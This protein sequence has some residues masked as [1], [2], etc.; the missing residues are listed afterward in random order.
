MER[1]S[2]SSTRQSGK[3]SITRSQFEA[4]S[5]WSLIRS[6]GK[7]LRPP[8][9]WQLSAQAFRLVA[10]RLQ[11]DAMSVVAALLRDGKRGCPNVRRRT[12]QRGHRLQSG[13]QRNEGWPWL[14]DHAWSCSSS[15]RNWE[16][17]DGATPMTRLSLQLDREWGG[18]GSAATRHDRH[19][20]CGF[21]QE[22]RH[23]LI[24]VRPA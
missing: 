1:D 5:P 17:G 8:C 11:M 14:G 2:S 10:G 20:D 9:L 15:A 13:R 7:G 3:A 18:S 12:Q 6:D 4:V 21:G 23:D 24:V 22:C 16:G 19:P